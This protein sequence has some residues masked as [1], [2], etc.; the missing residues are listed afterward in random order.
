MNVL[1]QDG[2]F[3]V[4]D[5]Y[6]QW[7]SADSGWFLNE[8]E[9]ILDTGFDYQDN[10][11]E[12]DDGELMFPDYDCYVDNFNSDICSAVVKNIHEL[13]KVLFSGELTKYL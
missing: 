3:L 10:M 4:I 13:I 5:G 1:V 9:I 8:K 7:S 12:D 6:I 11:I 2:N